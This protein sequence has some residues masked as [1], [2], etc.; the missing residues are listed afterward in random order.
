M[1]QAEGPAGAKA[2]KW[3]C[4]D[5][6]CGWS[7]VSETLGQDCALHPSAPLPSA[8]CSHPFLT[9]AHSTAPKL[10]GAKAPQPQSCAAPGSRVNPNDHT[11]AAENTAGT[12]AARED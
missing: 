10:H 3:E 12:R 2:G 9:Q 6:R 4:A 5:K 7:G 11:E 8:Q 1:R